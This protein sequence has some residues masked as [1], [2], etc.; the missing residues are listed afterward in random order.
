ML[1]WCCW[2]CKEIAEI[3]RVQ[4]IKLLV[5]H[6]EEIYCENCGRPNASNYWLLK[7]IKEFWYL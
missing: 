5:R 3:S 7:N 1:L 2:Y 6:Q 4:E